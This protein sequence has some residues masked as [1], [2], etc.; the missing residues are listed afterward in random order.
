MDIKKVIRQKGWTIER[1]AEQMT[2]CKGDNL[3]KKGISQAALSKLLSDPS[4]IPYGRL[5]EIAGIIG[6]SVGELVNEDG[7]RCPYCGKLLKI[8][9]DEKEREVS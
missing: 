2:A 6:G 9:R 4:K 1:L 5:Q 3:G 7:V 8:D